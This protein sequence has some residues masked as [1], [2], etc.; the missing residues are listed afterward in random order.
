MPQYCRP[1]DG[2]KHIL[3]GFEY[4]ANFSQLPLVSCAISE[5]SEGM[6]E[7]PVSL[8]RNR[9]RELVKKTKILRASFLPTVKTQLGQR[10]I[11]YSCFICRE[12]KHEGA[13]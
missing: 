6:S 9:S 5:E 12:L 10:K 4:L 8:Q 3:S 7:F 1:A 11:H 13:K 2:E